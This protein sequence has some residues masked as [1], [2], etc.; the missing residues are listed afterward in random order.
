MA[1]EKI[2]ITRGLA[3]LKLLDS[4]ITKTISN[5]AFV[6]TY[7]RRQDLT[8]GTKIKKVDFEKNALAVKTT[9]DDLIKR[10]GVIKSKI[11]QSNADTYVEISGERYTVIG[12]IER[13]NSIKY[14]KA[15]L[16]QMRLNLGHVRNAIEDQKPKLED[17]VQNMLTQNLGG[18]KK[19]SKDDYD[20]IARPF[21]EANELLM[22]DPC[23]VER[24]IDFLD[25]K[26]DEFLSEVDFVL[27]ESNSR[28]EIEI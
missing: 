15:L 21:I 10:R 25:K 5:A 16:E 11:L 23:N 1:L 9:I 6:D 17:S 26:I 14:E 12:A 18:D 8:L 7:Q 24:Q 13:K 28:T 20:L 4:R 3:E 27:S 19:A 2:T 22:L